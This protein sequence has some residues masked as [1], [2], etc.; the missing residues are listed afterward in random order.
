MELNEIVTFYLC[1]SLLEWKLYENWSQMFLIHYC[2]H[3][4]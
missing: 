2:V 4:A 1:L 3:G